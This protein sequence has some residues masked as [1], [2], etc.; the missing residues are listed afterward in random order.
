MISRL[1]DPGMTGQFRDVIIA[2][3]TIEGSG[4]VALMVFDVT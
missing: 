4:E 1:A 2:G 3:A